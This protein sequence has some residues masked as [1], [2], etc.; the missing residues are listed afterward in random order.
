MG[1]FAEGFSPLTLTKKAW[2]ERAPDLVERQDIGNRASD[3]HA[4]RR[5][6]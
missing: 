4:G 2:G 3:S 5:L 6:S 1:G